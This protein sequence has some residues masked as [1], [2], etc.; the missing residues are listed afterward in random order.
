LMCCL[1]Y[2]NDCYAG[3]C[4]KK[5][6]PPKVGAVVVTMSGEG[7]VLSVSKN[8]QTAT[9]R[10]FEGNKMVTVDWEEAV[11]KEDE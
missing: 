6:Q 2:E 9:I 1:K 5:V 3:T 11:E 4:P 10:L 8:K 7:K